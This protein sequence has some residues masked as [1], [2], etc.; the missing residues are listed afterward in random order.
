[1]MQEIL[2]K[3]FNIKFNKNQFPGS[4]GLIRGERYIA[5]RKGIFFKFSKQRAEI[6]NLIQDKHLIS[7]QDFVLS[8]CITST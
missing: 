7:M 6:S 2:V 8:V 5:K 4:R 1:M 3:F